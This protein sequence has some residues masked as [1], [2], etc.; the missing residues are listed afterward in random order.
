MTTHDEI[1]Q[2]RASLAA[3]H[4]SETR[5]ADRVTDCPPWRHALPGALLG[6]YIG[7]IS[8]SMTMQAWAMPLVLLAVGVI[9]WTERRRK[10]LFV[11]GFRRGKTLPITLVF[12]AVITCLV[13]AALHMREHDFSIWSKL[14]LACIAFALTTAF[15]IVRQRIFR[16]EL[17]EGDA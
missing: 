17:T 4:S 16:S 7:A 15:S 9:I 14:A 11:H 1:D 8:I 10:G 3:V 12:V 13:V 6:A 2:A 5:L